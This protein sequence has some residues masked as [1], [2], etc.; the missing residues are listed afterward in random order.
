MKFNR[1]GVSENA[2]TSNRILI[3]QSSNGLSY[4]VTSN[5]TA[6]VND[7][8]SGYGLNQKL[9]IAAK[10]KQNNFALWVN[11]FEVITV[12]SGNTPTNLNSLDFK[13][14]RF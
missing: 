8:V 10:Y 6:V 1:L 9:K 11:G 7:N 13:G 2:S 4:L 14:S 12:S 5:T 3:G